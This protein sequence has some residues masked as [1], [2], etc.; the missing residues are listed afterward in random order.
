MRG[1][2][3][4]RSRLLDGWFMTGREQSSSAAR[5][6]AKRNKGSGQKDTS[7]EKWYGSATNTGA[8]VIS[9]FTKQDASG[10][11][12][13]K[14]IS[15]HSHAMDSHGPGWTQF[16]WI[17]VWWIQRVR[18]SRYGEG[19]FR[20]LISWTIQFQQTC[21]SNPPSFTPGLHHGEKAAQRFVRLHVRSEKGQQ[22]ISPKKLKIRAN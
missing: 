16:K 11:R 13:G 2:L 8:A 9:M 18:G 15:F 17:I 19:S 20:P 7:M 3:Q 12:G 6:N 22:P 14:S 10:L 5:Q 4:R 21:R 1:T